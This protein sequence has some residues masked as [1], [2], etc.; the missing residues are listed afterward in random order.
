[1]TI[2]LQRG[3]LTSCD[4]KGTKIPIAPESVVYTT[5]SEPPG[6]RVHFCSDRTVSPTWKVAM[7]SAF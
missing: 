1:M 3:N 6:M 2:G 4:V 7:G 5:D